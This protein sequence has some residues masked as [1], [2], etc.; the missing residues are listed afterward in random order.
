MGNTELNHFMLEIISVISYQFFIIF[1]L[2][3]F[4]FHI[5][6]MLISINFFFSPMV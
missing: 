6:I 3:L 4:V 5:I 1:I 2:V